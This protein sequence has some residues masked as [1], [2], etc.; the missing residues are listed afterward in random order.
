MSSDGRVTAGGGATAARIAGATDRA[1]AWSLTILSMTSVQLGTAL[2][3]GLFGAVGPAGTVWLRFSAGALIF[4]A[5]RRPRLRG[6]SRN[7][8]ASALALGVTTGAMSV[9]FLSAVARIP[10]GTTV[11]IEFVGPLVV[12]VAS[13]PSRGRLALPA[14][15]LGGVLLLTQPWVV[16]AVDPLGVL[17]AAGAAT[18]WGLYIVLTAQVGDRF[19]GLEGLSITI[20]IA[21]LTAAVVGVPQAAAGQLTLTTLVAALGLAVLQPVLPFS[22]ELLA[23][24][25]LTKSAFGT[26]MALEPAIGLTIG[27]LVLAQAPT[28]LQALGVALIVVAGIGAARGGGRSPLPPPA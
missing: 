12:A 28:V 13:A 8:L 24:R 14:L 21:A 19:E 4:L 6:R 22:L 3:T 23:L 17:L 2:A 1:P 18:G 25:R 10:L 11:A 16:G 15:A 26:L 9:C 5:I 7:E 27:A 20:P